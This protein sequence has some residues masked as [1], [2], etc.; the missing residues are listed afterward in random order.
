MPGVL[1]REKTQRHRERR[2]V[3]DDGDRD[4]SDAATSQ[5]CLEPPGAGR[6]RKDPPLGPLEGAQPCDTWI[7]NFWPPEPGGNELY[8]VVVC[9]PLCGS[10]GILKVTNT[11][12]GL[13]MPSPSEQMGP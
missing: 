1:I 7:L 5:E 6:G 13:R 10:H 11:G 9:G 3:C 2:K 12:P 4:E 8:V